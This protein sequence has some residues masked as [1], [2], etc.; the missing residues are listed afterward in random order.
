MH[1]RYRRT[2]RDLPVGGGRLVLQLQVRRFRCAN[3]RCPTVTFVEQVP[4]V[5]RA[6]GRYTAAAETLLGAVGLALAGRAGARLAARLGLGAGRDTLLRRIRALPEQPVGTVEVLGVDD[7][8][9]RRGHRYGT[10]MV[11]LSTHRPVDM[12]DGR[13]GETFATWLRAHPGTQVIC[14]DRA[15]GYAEGARTGAPSAIEVADRFHLWQNLGQAVEKTVNTLRVN[16]AA[17]V[18]AAAP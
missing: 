3:D 9:F 11:D 14:R 15:G 8:A 7:F 4:G 6:H 12:I 1:G 17:P 18:P 5:T 16:L 10:V 2:V 13:D